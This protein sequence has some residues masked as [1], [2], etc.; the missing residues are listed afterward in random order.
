LP[1]RV[2][3]IAA[4]LGADFH[5]RLVQLGFDLFLQHHFAIGQDL[6]NVRTQLARLGIDDLQFFLDA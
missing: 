1:S 3:G 4:N 6:L 5:S 2:S